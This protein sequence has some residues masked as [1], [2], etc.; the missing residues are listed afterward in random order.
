MTVYD[1]FILIK[2]TQVQETRNSM[3]SQFAKLLV[4]VNVSY[5]KENEFLAEEVL[6]KGG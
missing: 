1:L 5:K 4:A 2:H 6:T 3:H